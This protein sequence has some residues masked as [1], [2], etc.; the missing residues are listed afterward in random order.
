MEYDV[1][2]EQV[3][4]QPLLVVRRKASSQE[5]AKV[6]PDACGTVWKV[7]QSQKI[8]GAG[9]HIALYLDNQINLEVGVELDTPIPG[10]GEVIE[11]AIPSGTV[12]TTVHFGPYNRLHEAHRAILDWCANNNYI[13]AGPSWEIYGHWTE[14][15]NHD[16]T[17]IRTDI[18][19]LLNPMEG[20]PS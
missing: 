4:S 13:L 14:E 12:V 1:R 20:S 8:P 18:F 2:V 16:S 3:N 5:L 9:R 7:I 19:Y 6:V 15:C 17:K 11:S 10:V